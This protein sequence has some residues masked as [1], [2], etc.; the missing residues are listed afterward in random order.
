[1][2]ESAR[3][4]IDWLTLPFLGLPAG[5]ICIAYINNTQPS[6]IWIVLL[7]FDIP[8]A[9]AALIWLGWRFL[10]SLPRGERTKRTID[11]LTLLPIGFLPALRVWLHYTHTEHDHPSAI[12]GALII[13]D[14][15]LSVASI[16]WLGFRTDKIR[17][18]RWWYY[19]F[20]M[21]PL[22][23]LMTALGFVV[24]ILFIKALWR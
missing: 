13:I 16:T 2:N 20:G 1:M 23:R 15:P 10:I 7:I 21:F 24:I 9:T 19:N 3:R 18:L 5:I 11:W 14:V 8:F 6:K 12:L 17:P 4:I 22:G